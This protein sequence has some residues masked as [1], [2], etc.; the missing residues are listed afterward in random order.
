MGDAVK[1]Q[2]NAKKIAVFCAFPQTFV[3]FELDALS[4][5]TISIR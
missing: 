2:S 4:A 3:D 1:A 5:V